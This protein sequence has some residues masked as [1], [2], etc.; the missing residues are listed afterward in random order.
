MTSTITNYK[1][2]FNS[3]FPVA[4]VDNNS[5]GFRDNFQAI[6]YAFSVAS[7]EVSDLQQNTAKLTTDNDFGGNSLINATII[8]SGVPAISYVGGS[9]DIDYSQGQFHSITLEEGNNIINIT[10][11]PGIGDA[12]VDLKSGS[13]IVSVTTASTVAT[14]LKFA[15][16][17]GT[18][19]NLGPIDIGAN[20]DFVDAAFP[21]D[22]G[23]THVFEIWNDS[24][25]VPPKIY[26]KKLSQNVSGTW[27]NQYID[28][29]TFKGIYSSFTNVISESVTIGRNNFTE[30]V[31]TGT[32]GA[33][34]ITN[35][36]EWGNIAL[37]PNQVTTNITD[38]AV[39]SPVDGTA[40]KFGVTSVNGIHLGSTVA[41]TNSNRLYVVSNIDTSAKVITVTP[42]FKVGI[43]LVP[44]TFTNPIFSRQ[45]TVVTLTTASTNTNIVG[46]I[47]A[48][49]NTFQIIFTAAT[50]TTNTTGTTNTFVISNILVN[51]ITTGSGLSISSSTGYVVMTNTGVLSI[52]VSTGTTATNSTGN[53][54][55]GPAVGYN[56]YGKRWI[57]NTRPSTSVGEDGDIWYKY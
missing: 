44:A 14:T 12:G 37:V 21:V 50:T 47:Y 35:N 5:Q 3:G 29:I 11:M 15:A 32:V 13:M 34:V 18:V 26:I 20:K 41:F 54:V 52:T 17:T 9:T 6:K 43:G 19:V 4:G 16:T 49:T 1:Y 31:Y 28:S 42:P 39:D 57:E 27:T 2:S 55:I 7:N 48:T 56:G 8:N 45:P 25:I 10:N 36:T 53:V 40:T 23:F 33:T 24:S 38:A 30:G 51:S 46:S 22:Q